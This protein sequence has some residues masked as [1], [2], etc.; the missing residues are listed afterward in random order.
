MIYAEQILFK[1]EDEY[2]TQKAGWEVTSLT[3]LLELI[4][5]ISKQYT[6]N[7][8][9]DAVSLLRVADII[10]LL[11]QKYA[12]PWKLENLTEIANMSPGNLIRV[13][14]KAT[15]QTPIDYLIGIRLKHAVSLLSI[16]SL[17]ITEIAFQTG[18]SDTNYFSRLFKQVFKCSP[19][20]YRLKYSYNLKIRNLY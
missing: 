18:F 11:E 9:P 19:R 10:S 7:K 16:T 5:Y 6:N 4:I 2:T 20:E 14:S 1:I 8:S 12:D 3:F 15:G 17:N 13:F